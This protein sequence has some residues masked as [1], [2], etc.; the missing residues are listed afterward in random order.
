[1]SLLEPTYYEANPHIYWERRYFY[2]CEL[3]D[4]VKKMKRGLRRLWIIKQHR[5][6]AWGHYQ[7]GY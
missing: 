7:R 2:L 6:S 5:L 4:R 1:M 3:Y